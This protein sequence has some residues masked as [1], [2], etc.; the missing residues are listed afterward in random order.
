MVHPRGGQAHM[1]KPPVTRC[2]VFALVHSKFASADA[3]RGNCAH[4]EPR[5]F[6]FVFHSSPESRVRQALLALLPCSFRRAPS[7]SPVYDDADDDGL[8]PLGEGDA[9]VPGNRVGIFWGA[10]VLDQVCV[11]LEGEFLIELPPSPALPALP[12]HHFSLHQPPWWLVY[13]TLLA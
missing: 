4:H 5:I 13:Q 7:V 9:A 2:C 11:C 1:H 10:P 8:T 6:T 3:G 12:P